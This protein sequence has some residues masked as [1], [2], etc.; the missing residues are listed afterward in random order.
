MAKKTPF[1][2]KLTS[3][4]AILI[5]FGRFLLFF[6]IFRLHLHVFFD[7][8]LTFLCFL[9]I[10]GFKKTTFLRAL[11]GGSPAGA[12]TWQKASNSIGFGYT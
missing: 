5:V 8:A 6:M 3:M 9:E 2:T 4:T 10:L 7:I 12:K 1:R 11:T